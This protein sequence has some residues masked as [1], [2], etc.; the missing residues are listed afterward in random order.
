ME[1]ETTLL[2]TKH[3]ITSCSQLFSVSETQIVVCLLV[4]K[5]EVIVTSTARAVKE[6]IDRHCCHCLKAILSCM[7]INLAMDSSID[8]GRD[9]FI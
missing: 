9:V 1:G 4:S 6:R 7:I 8:R 3:K 5:L 2:S